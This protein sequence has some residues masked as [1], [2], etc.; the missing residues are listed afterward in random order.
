MNRANKAGSNDACAHFR[1]C[2]RLSSHTLPPVFKMKK[3]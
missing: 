3:N 1:L 2:I